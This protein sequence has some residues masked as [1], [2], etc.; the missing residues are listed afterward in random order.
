MVINRAEGVYIVNCVY[1]PV[2]TWKSISP[3]VLRVLGPSE[4]MTKKVLSCSI[5]ELL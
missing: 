5:L 4:E 1:D 3:V 2:L